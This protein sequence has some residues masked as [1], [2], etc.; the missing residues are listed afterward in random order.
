MQ[1]KCR[2]DACTIRSET[3]WDTV[4]VFENIRKYEL[5]NYFNGGVFRIASEGVKQNI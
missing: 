2:I 3:C 1:F 5:C 4:L